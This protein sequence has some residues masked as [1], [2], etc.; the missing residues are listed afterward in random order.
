MSM[1]VK[2]GCFFVVFRKRKSLINNE[3]GCLFLSLK[4]NWQAENLFCF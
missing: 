1:S 4:I 2:K 3:L